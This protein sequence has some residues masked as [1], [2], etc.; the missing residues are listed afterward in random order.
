[1][2]N[3]RLLLQTTIISLFC[4]SS[5]MNSLIASNPNLYNGLPGF[6]VEAPSKRALKKLQHDEL[7]I[8][9]EAKRHPYVVDFRTRE[10]FH[11]NFKNGLAAHWKNFGMYDEVVFLENSQFKTAFYNQ[12]SELIGTS[13]NKKFCDLPLKGQEIISKKYNVWNI[14]QVIW[15]D[16]NENNVSDPLSNLYFANHDNYFIYL[17]KGDKNIVLKCS[18]EGDMDIFT[19]RMTR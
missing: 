10:A 18:L 13:V 6:Y 19:D 9:R 15:Y 16:D 3:L 2:K 11:T 7:K 5:F 12:N 1:M 17:S 4:S 8:K 14:R